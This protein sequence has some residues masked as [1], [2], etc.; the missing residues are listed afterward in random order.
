MHEEYLTE[1]VLKWNQNR[2][3]N[4]PKMLLKREKDVRSSYF[5]FHFSVHEN[6]IAHL[7]ELSLLCP[8]RVSGF[9]RSPASIGVR[10]AVLSSVGLNNL[11]SVD[12]TCYV[13]E[14]YFRNNLR[15]KIEKI[16]NI[17]A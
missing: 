10:H 14:E 11:N 13:D 9:C 2:I 6:I 5:L 3:V 12:F 17:R 16:K 4:L 1:L 15:L 8:G 7:P